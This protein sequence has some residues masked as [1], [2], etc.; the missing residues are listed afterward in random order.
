MILK[1]RYGFL[2]I[3]KD[4]VFKIFNDSKEYPAERDLLSQNIFSPGVDNN[5]GY[6]LDFVT[7]VHFGISFYVMKKIDGGP[8][9]NSEI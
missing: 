2:I 8:F 9:Y 3:N 5:S 6:K 1:R 4:S 7:I